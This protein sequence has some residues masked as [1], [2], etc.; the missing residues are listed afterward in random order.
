MD[1]LRRFML[2][3]PASLHGSP[4]AVH[5][6][7]T[8]VAALPA[9]VEADSRFDTTGQNCLPARLALA[10]NSCSVTPNAVTMSSRPRNLAPPNALRAIGARRTPLP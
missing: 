3:A 4:P 8:G 6:E 1:R 5:A 9:S 10:G 2:K 7:S